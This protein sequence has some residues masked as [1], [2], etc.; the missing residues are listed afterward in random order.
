MTII[1]RKSQENYMAQFPKF[2]V[3]VGQNFDISSLL[4][5]KC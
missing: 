5:S 2:N 4:H 1:V 3:F